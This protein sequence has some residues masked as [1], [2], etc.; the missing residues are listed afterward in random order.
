LEARAP[1]LDHRLADVAGKLPIRL[2]VTPQETKVA[3]R[4]IAEKLLPPELAKRR[5]KG[6]S[7]PIGHWFRNELRTWVRDCL[8]DSSQSVPALF[9]RDVVERV[10]AEHETKRRDHS[11]RIYSLMTLELWYRRHFA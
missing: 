3:L 8:L 11:R 10:L 5:K 6:F 9:N 7:F 4:R 2:K 1:L